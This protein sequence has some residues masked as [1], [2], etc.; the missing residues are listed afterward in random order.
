MQVPIEF[1]AGL[2]L[3]VGIT[4]AS[5]CEPALSGT[6][7]LFIKE[8]NHTLG[9]GINVNGQY[10][11][12]LAI[13]PKVEHAHYR[14]GP[15]QWL[16]ASNLA[17]NSLCQLDFSIT[18]ENCA[19]IQSVGAWSFQLTIRYRLSLV[20]APPAYSTRLTSIATPAPRG[21]SADMEQLA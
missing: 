20:V 4:A 16:D 17:G 14:P 12:V 7:T 15:V 6:S 8:N 19:V 13:I 18:D 1:K 9:G 21:Y 2:D 5:I 3:E 11:G 10:Y